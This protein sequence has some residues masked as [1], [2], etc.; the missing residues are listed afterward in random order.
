MILARLDRFGYF[1]EGIFESEEKARQEILKEYKKKFFRINNR[2][3][4]KEEIEL[5][6]INFYE[7][8]INKVYWN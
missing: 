4:T 8:K 3:P 2:K 1:L 6:D 5:L 7:Q